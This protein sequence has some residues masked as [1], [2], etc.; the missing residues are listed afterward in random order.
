M[1]HVNIHVPYHLKMGVLLHFQ[2]PMLNSTK[3]I[4]IIIS[5]LNKRTSHLCPD[6][7]K[8]FRINILY[9]MS[10]ETMFDK[11]LFGLI[12]FISSFGWLDFLIYFFIW[13][14]FISLLLRNIRLFFKI[15][16]RNHSDVISNVCNHILFYDIFLGAIFFQRC[17]LWWISQQ[18][19]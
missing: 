11:N 13:W 7:H 18:P 9:L 6:T 4:F 17:S 10:S 2:C 19:W 14:Y 5:N 12:L 3:L 16:F 15:K 1:M 8:A